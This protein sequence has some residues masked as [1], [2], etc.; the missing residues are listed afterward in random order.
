MMKSMVA[1][2]PI[3]VFFGDLNQEVRAASRLETASKLPS[4]KAGKMVRGA[5]LAAVLC[6]P[7]TGLPAQE[8][9]QSLEL[10][11]GLARQAQQQGDYARAAEEWKAI[12]K[13]SPKLAKAH[14]NL[15]MMYQLLHQQPAAIESFETA[16]QLNPG[17]ASVRV[18]LG[19]EYYLT[20]RPDLAIEQLQQ[21]LRLQ[22]QD[23]MARKWLGLSYLYAGYLGRAVPELRF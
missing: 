3:G 4:H 5:L 16:L 11:Y 17:L 12:V 1:T 9:P 21:A 19:I 6:V 14:A 20:S 7:L 10:H 8:N 22:P 15:G 2:G 23:P 13:L 18:F